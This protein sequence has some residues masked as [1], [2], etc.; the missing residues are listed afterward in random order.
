LKNIGPVHG[1]IH[2]G[3]FGSTRLDEQQRST[4][5]ALTQTRLEREIYLNSLLCV[6]ERKEENSNVQAANGNGRPQIL[7]RGGRTKVVGE[8]K[9]EL[10]GG[11]KKKGEGEVL[12]AAKK[13]PTRLVETRGRGKKV[14]SK[15]TK[16]H[17]K[18]GTVS[19]SQCGKGVF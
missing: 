8:R 13:T 4:G 1:R 2:S 18:G 10:L 6:F 17:P 19:G 3:R 14:E 12:E 15:E 7:F 9:R 16:S 11:I 5:K